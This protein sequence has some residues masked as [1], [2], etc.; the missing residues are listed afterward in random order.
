MSDK[1]VVFISYSHL[2]EPVRPGPDEVRWLTYVQSFLQ[3]AMKHA[4][5]DLW[6]DEN[7]PG[8]AKWEE[9]IKEKLAACDICILL[10]SRHSLNSQYCINIEVGAIERRQAAG[11]N[12]H[13]YPVILSPAPRAAL[14]RIGHLNFR[15]KNGEP[16][17][18]FSKNERDAVMANIADEIVDMLGGGDAGP[19]PLP[20]PKPSPSPGFVHITGLPETAYARLVGREAELTQLDEAWRDSKTNI[21]SLIAEGGAGK[22]ALVNEWLEQLR[23]NNYRSAEAVLG[24][25]FYSQG[26]KERATSAEGF[27]NWAIEKLDIQIETTSASAK[28]DAIAEA[29]AKRRI[30]LVLDG[31][32]PLQ[33]GPGTQTGQLKDLGLRSLLRRFA[34]TPAADAHGLIVLTSRLAIADIARWKDISAPIVDV[35]RLSDQAGAALLRDIGVWGT[36]KELHA[37]AREFGGHP[38]ALALLAT[39]LKETQLG[40][41]RR[42]NQVHSFV[43]DDDNPLHGHARRV[44]A[45]YEDEWLKGQPILLAILSIVG[46]FDRPATP[47]CLD[48]LRREPAIVGLTDEIVELTAVDWNRAITRLREVG[49]LAPMD[50]SAP[51]A[52]DAH[53]I[54][55]E[56]FGERLKVTARDAW[57][58]A[59]ARL[60]EHL[61]DTS[62]EGDSPTLRSLTPLYQAIAHACRAGRHGEALQEVYFPRICRLRSDGEFDFYSLRQLSAYGT[63]V[64][65]FSWFF[66]SPYEKLSNALDERFHAFVLN[67]TAHCLRGQGRIAEALPAQRVS[68]LKIQRHAGLARHPNEEAAIIASEL[69]EAEC[70][71]GNMKAAL[72]TAAI[73]VRFADAGLR[74]FYR[75]ATRGRLAQMYLY[76]GELKRAKALFA[77]AELRQGELESGHHFLRR[78]W[79]YNFDDLLLLQGAY[80]EVL[81]RVT[82][83]LGWASD[84]IAQ[85]ERVLDV[86]S[87]GKAC[88]GIALTH[89][90]EGSPTDEVRTVT[91]DAESNLQASYDRLK[92]LGQNDELPRAALAQ[93][94]LYR[95]AASWGMA[96]R[97]LDEVEEIAE[98]GPMKLFLCDLALERAR[99][100]FAQIEAFAPLNGMLEKDNPPKPEVPSRE[101][102]AELKAEAEK[103]IKIADDYIQSCGYHRRDEELAELKDVLVGKRTFAS[104]PPRV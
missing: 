68:L 33:H 67:T 74:P 3:P 7:I 58:A 60:Y 83:K 79:G 29:L 95:S 81:S 20:T 18:G 2:D 25:S 37:A 36:D 21:L 23:K 92:D 48:A 66:D 13:V 57:R 6:V 31:V 69:S 77:D 96:L 93:S 41:V 53:P 8:G 1:P 104:L 54:V 59:N 87:F 78:I 98:P 50:H 38:L 32:E 72:D 89:H 94:I 30:L 44:M 42:R 28:G 16:L 63:E 26:T 91:R 40:D 76:A 35:E 51:N 64:A 62:D 102:I 12:V 90:A 11:E 75:M 14:K 71:A 61:R 10:V 4:I 9:H 84:Y 45:S 65:M 101:K 70:V 73:S 19:I 34:A 86:L 100:A 49:L 15:P 17:S 43:D 22:S 24:W 52:L 56:W 39:F 103:Q 46:L 88:L 99:L 80:K 85:F 47:D 55:R 97:N 5:F 82:T 27:L